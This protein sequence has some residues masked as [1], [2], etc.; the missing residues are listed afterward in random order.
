V[1]QQSISLDRIIDLRGARGRTGGARQRRLSTGGSAK[2]DSVSCAP[3]GNCSAGG[4]CSYDNKGK[5]RAFV[6]AS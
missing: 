4:S 6:V 1:T 3:A 5:S 2:I